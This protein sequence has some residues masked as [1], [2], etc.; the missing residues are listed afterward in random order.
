M[1]LK[2][3]LK[4]RL[5][6]EPIDLDDEEQLYVKTMSGIDRS[7]FYDLSSTFS[8]EKKSDALAKSNAVLVA[9]CLVNEA[10]ENIY[11]IDEIG[12]IVELDS[13]DIENI[14]EKALDLNKLNQKSQEG[15][16]KN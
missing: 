5:K 7:V 1:G 10:W 9:L 11:T 2:E 4:A 16:E 8:K 3:R 6:R 12:D 13:T 14:M 15:Q